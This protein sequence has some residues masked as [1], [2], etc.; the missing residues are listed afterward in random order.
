LSA[1]RDCRRQNVSHGDIKSENVLVT[2]WNFVYLTDFASS[3]KPV[4]LPLDNPSDFAFFYDTSGR[5]NCYIAPERFY[6]VE[7]PGTGASLHAG[8]NIHASS[9]TSAREG[10]LTEA[11]DVFSAGCVCAEL[12]LDGAPL[13]TLSQLFK[14][15]EGEL[16]LDAQLAAIEEEGMRVRI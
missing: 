12:F 14:Y 6:S 8:V 5:R 13:F 16:S 7:K 3:F 11:M 10:K 1:L 9:S 4:Y 15:R 2:S